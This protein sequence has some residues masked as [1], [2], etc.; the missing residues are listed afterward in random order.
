MLVQTA[1]LREG[2]LLCG[3]EKLAGQELQ[4][5]SVLEKF[6]DLGQNADQSYQAQCFGTNPKTPGPSS[7]VD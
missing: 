1:E 2:S 4:L 7:I 5:N 6:G 3:L